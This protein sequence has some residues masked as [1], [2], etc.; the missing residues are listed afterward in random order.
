MWHAILSF[1]ERI[2]SV[3]VTFATGDYWAITNSIKALKAALA[4]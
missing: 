3:W 2:F 1:L 4:L